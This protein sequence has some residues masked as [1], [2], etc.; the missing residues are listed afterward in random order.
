MPTLLLSTKF[1]EIEISSVIA[2]RLGKPEMK[3][4]SLLPW[5]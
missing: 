1:M 3:Y 5:K 4:K 2:G